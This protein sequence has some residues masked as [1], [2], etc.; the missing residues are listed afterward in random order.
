[1][2][3]LRLIGF[4]AGI[5]LLVAVSALGLKSA[6]DDLDAVATFGQQAVSA[7]QFGYALGGFVAAGA[8]LARRSW[9]RKALLL[10]AGVLT[11]TGGLAPVVWGGT[12]ISVGLVAGAATA[13]VAALVIWLASLR[14]AP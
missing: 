6:V 12:G 5:A 7:T 3:R 1:M 14:R 4:W 8:L 10:W 2:S 11:L 13:A 9:A